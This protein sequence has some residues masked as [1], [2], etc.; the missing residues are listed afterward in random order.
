MRSLSSI[1]LFY[2]SVRPT[3]SLHAFST[4]HFC[5][6]IKSVETLQDVINADADKMSACIKFGGDDDGE[7]AS[8]CDVSAQTSLHANASRH[9]SSCRIWSLQDLPALN[10]FANQYVMIDCGGRYFN[11]H[12][13]LGQL[14]M[15]QGSTLHYH[16]CSLLRYALQDN[17]R[18]YNTLQAISSS[19]I[20]M[21]TC[22]VSVCNC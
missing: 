9:R 4:T 17:N 10:I 11:H 3:T 5:T 21:N 18:V 22:Q 19:T 7:C 8:Q 16:N 12:S 2:L 20:G 1:I 14:T 13:S 15:G 6:E